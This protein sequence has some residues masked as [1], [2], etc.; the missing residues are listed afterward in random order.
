MGEGRGIRR[1]ESA[2]HGSACLSLETPSVADVNA[3]AKLTRIHQ[4]LF[5]SG[6]TIKTSGLV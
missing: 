3:L 2:T 4:I 1:R 6:I 5:G